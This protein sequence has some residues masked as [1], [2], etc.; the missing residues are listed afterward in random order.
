MPMLM[1]FEKV[2]AWRFMPK[3]HLFVAADCFRPNGSALTALG[4][5]SRGG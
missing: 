4:Q 5:T 2:D 3:S 1:L